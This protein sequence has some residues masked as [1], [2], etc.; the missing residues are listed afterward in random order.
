VATSEFLYSFKKTGSPC[1]MVR[2][3]VT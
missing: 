3:A 1:A 2:D